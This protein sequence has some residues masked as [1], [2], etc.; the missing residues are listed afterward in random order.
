MTL[1]TGAT[2]GAYFYTR[3]H[4]G[5]IRE[6]TDST[7]RIRARYSYDPFGR[8]THLTG[9]LDTDFGFAG[10]LYP[11]ELDLNMTKFRAYDPDIGRWLSRDPLND[12]E[13]KAGPESLRLRRQQP[14][15][16]D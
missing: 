9:D 3:D 8:P 11:P 1:E 12:A 15:Q 2:P 7:G 16:P 10:M 13:Q 14:G 6:L 4:L 5:S